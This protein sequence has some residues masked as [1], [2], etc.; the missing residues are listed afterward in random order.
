MQRDS[1]FSFL[2]PSVSQPPNG[3]NV[4][5]DIRQVV[6][7]TNL[8]ASNLKVWPTELN[9]HRAHLPFTIEIFLSVGPNP[10]RYPLR[11][12]KGLGFFLGKSQT[13]N[14]NHSNLSV[15]EP[16]FVAGKWAAAKQQFPSSR[17]SPEPPLG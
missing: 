13:L 16:S 3:P 8:W 9:S 4:T 1:E 14:P 2:F 5:N 10:G 17:T 12:G 15:C 6:E 7:P 11:Q